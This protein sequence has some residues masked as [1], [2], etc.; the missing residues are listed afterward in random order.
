MALFEARHLLELN[1]EIEKI[2]LLQ[3]T[4]HSEYVKALTELRD[5]LS[6]IK[7]ENHQPLHSDIRYESVS[8]LGNLKKEYL[9]SSSEDLEIPENQGVSLP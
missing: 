4:S 2:K 8:D 1:N 5:I 7:T 3:K 9:R 6:A